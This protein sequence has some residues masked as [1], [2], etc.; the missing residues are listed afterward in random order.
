MYLAIAT[1]PDIA[2]AVGKLSQFIAFFNHIHFTAA[3][4]VLRYLKGTCTLRLKLGGS[5]PAR[6]SGFSDASHACCPDSGKSVGT[7]CF[8]LSDTGIISWA[9]RKQKTVAQSTCD[10]EYMAVGEAARECMWL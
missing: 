2:F 7:Y 10:S 1:R 3:K 9:S 8:S 5:I 4:R 6:V